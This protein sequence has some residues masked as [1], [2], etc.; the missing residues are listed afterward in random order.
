MVDLG[1][2][3]GQGKRKGMG[4]NKYRVECAFGEGEEMDGLVDGMNR[5][6]GVAEMVE[7]R[8][9]GYGIRDKWYIINRDRAESAYP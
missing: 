4:E 3:D 9:A 2:A 5:N 8:R 6:R 7:K 1:G